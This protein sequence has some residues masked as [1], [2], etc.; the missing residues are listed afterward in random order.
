MSARKRQRPVLQRQRAN[1]PLKNTTPP[2]LYPSLSPSASQSRSRRRTPN[3]PRRCL[4]ECTRHHYPSELYLPSSSSST[5]LTEATERVGLIPR[6]AHEDGRAADTTVGMLYSTEDCKSFAYGLSAGLVAFRAGRNQDNKWASNW[7]QVP[8]TSSWSAYRSRRAETDVGVKP[9]PSLGFA[10]LRVPSASSKRAGHEVERLRPIVLE[11]FPMGSCTPTRRPDA[12]TGD[13]TMTPRRCG[14]R[15][16]VP[17]P[18]PYTCARSTGAR[19]VLPRQCRQRDSHR[20]GHRAACAHGAGGDDEPAAGDAGA[21]VLK[22]P[23]GTKGAIESADSLA[24]SMPRKGWNANEAL[25]MWVAPKRQNSA[26][27]G[28]AR[29]RSELGP[30]AGMDALERAFFQGGSKRGI[31]TLDATGR[32]KIPCAGRGAPS[33][34]LVEDLQTELREKYAQAPP[35]AW[36][37][38]TATAPHKKR[39]HALTHA[40]WP[41]HPLSRCGKRSKASCGVDSQGQVAAR[42]LRQERRWRTEVGPHEIDGSSDEARGHGPRGRVAHRGPNEQRQR[43]LV[44]GCLD[45]GIRHAVVVSMRDGECDGKQDQARDGD[46]ELSGCVDPG[47]HEVEEGDLEVPMGWGLSEVDLRGMSDEC[48]VGWRVMRSE[49]S[50]N[51]CK[52]TADASDAG[53]WKSWIRSKRLSWSRK[54][55]GLKGQ[56]IGTGSEEEETRERRSRR[57]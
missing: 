4:S 45:S 46:S 18:D 25:Y 41:E 10:R 48:S 28:K 54:H 36:N 16:A 17:A 27:E 53:H 31:K 6:R 13:S 15:I 56:G 42:G 19:V 26:I 29:T 33:A 30:C 50:Q 21:A 43:I 35:R 9:L 40:R 2:D 57:R 52:E 12:S 5:E 22:V 20:G 7:S 34:R 8:F 14:C 1:G 49:M 24:V 44:V 3:T 11:V 55:W 39:H 38:S 37:Q 23:R 51:N 47:T 32:A